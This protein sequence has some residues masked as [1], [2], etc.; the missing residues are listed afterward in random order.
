MAAPL[1][2]KFFA[3]FCNKDGAPRSIYDRRFGRRS[4]TKN[5]AGSEE[6]TEAPHVAQGATRELAIQ[7]QPI[8]ASEKPQ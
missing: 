8:N 1:A 2:T 5:T 7:L 3:R 4:I 6:R